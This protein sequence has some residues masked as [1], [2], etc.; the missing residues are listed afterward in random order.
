[1]NSSEYV[2][3]VVLDDGRTI[4]TVAKLGSR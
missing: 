1:L 3:D 4:R 2:I